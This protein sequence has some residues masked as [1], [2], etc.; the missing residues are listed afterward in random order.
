MNTRRSCKVGA[1]IWLVAIRD[2]KEGVPDADGEFTVDQLR[3]SLYNVLAPSGAGR[4][5][6]R[7]APHVPT[8]HAAQPTAISTWVT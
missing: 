4:P 5:P 8:E 3:P 1:T 6:H 2:A 7:S